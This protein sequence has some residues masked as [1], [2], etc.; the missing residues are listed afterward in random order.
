MHNQNVFFEFILK[1]NIFYNNY[2][3]RFICIFMDASKAYVNKNI[4]KT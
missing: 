1:K 4:Y 2:Y 3:R